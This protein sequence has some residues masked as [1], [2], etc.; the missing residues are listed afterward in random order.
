MVNRHPFAEIVMKM[1]L[2]PP[3]EPWKRDAVAIG[4]L[5]EIGY[6][7]DSDYLLAISET[8]GVF[9]CS[10]GVQN[11][12]VARDYDEDGWVNVWRDS[13]NLT[14][15]GI[16]PIEGQT[17]RLAGLWGG[18]LSMFTSDGWHVELAY[19][20]WPT[21]NV[22]LCPPHCYPFHRGAEQCLK[23]GTWTGNEYETIIG[24]GFSQTGKSFI[25]AESHTIEIFS[26]P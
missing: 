22:I 8:R 26:R 20:N 24:C 2:Q 12:K 15:I 1:P 21:P 23:L 5:T 4:G 14:A 6:A 16:G 7:P 18:G 3:P 19:P 13:K 10:F 17:V 25:I 9:D 11:R